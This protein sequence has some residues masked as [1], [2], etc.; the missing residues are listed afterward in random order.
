MGLARI[1]ALDLGKF[2]TVACVM[3]A[4]DRSHVFETIEM[5]PHSVHALL[6][7]HAT[8]DSAATL[9]VFET[10]D[11]SGWVYDL[12]VALA[13]PAR[14]VAANTEAWHRGLVFLFQMLVRAD[15]PCQQHQ[16]QRDPRADEHQLEC[17]GPAGVGD[18]VA[19][20]DQSA[21]HERADAHA[22]DDR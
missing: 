1:I 14:V 3:N 22:G 8:E 5:S 4:V 9:V 2:K 13:L 16:D 7:R 21:L 17:G 6:V 18:A 10:C 20:D 12:C 15:V 11:C 19:G